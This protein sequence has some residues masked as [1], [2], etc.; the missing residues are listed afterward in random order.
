[1][2][3]SQEFGE[4]HRAAEGGTWS[5]HN[6]PSSAGFS[7]E[8]VQHPRSSAA[9]QPLSRLLRT[10]LTVSAQTFPFLPPSLLLSFSSR[11]RSLLRVPWRGWD[12][13]VVRSLWWMCVAL[14]TLFRVFFFFFFFLPLFHLTVSNFTMI[15]NKMRIKVCFYT[16]SYVFVV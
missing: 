13:E 9:A 11:R 8:Q 10:L 1:M 4:D 6:I 15:K 3:G 16:Y 7:C 12:C 5:E 2:C 14:K